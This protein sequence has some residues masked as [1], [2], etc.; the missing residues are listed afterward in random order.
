MIFILQPYIFWDNENIYCLLFIIWKPCIVLKN[1]LKKNKALSNRQ[2]SIVIQSNSVTVGLIDGDQSFIKQLPVQQGDFLGAI[3][4]LTQEIA[5]NNSHCQIVLTH[6]NYQ[7]V[8]VEQ[9]N[10]PTSEV[11]QALAW[12]AKD[13]FTIKPEDQILDYYQNHSNNPSLNK[14]NVVAANRAVIG[15]IVEF[16]HQQKVNISGIS[17]EDVVI[18]QLLKPTSANVLIFHLPG[19]QVLIAVVEDGKLCFSRHIHGYDNLH[20]MSEADFGLGML[21][22]LGLEVQRSIDYA[23]GQLR[24]DSIESIYVLIQNFDLE[25]LLTGMQEYF[26]LPVKSLK[27]EGDDDFIRFPINVAAVAELAMTENQS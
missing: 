9:P 13:L 22:N 2:L 6:G 26:D 12:S 1:L 11:A 7:V 14:L 5:I 17:I 24:I 10:V 23:L 18:T 8:Q 19:S 20:Q 21:T 16:L 4:S 3:T 25:H 15:P 27:I